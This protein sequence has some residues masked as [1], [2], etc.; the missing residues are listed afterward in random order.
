M[1]ENDIKFSDNCSRIVS[2]AE[3]RRKYKEEIKILTPKQLLQLLLV[4]LVQ[5]KAGN[6]SEN[7]L[8]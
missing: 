1:R 5:V 6:T 2:E 7:L 3:Y 4:S 8:N